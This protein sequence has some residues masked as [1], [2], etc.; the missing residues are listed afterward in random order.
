MWEPVLM[1]KMMQNDMFTALVWYGKVDLARNLSSKDELLAKYGV[2]W[3]MVTADWKC[4][5]GRLEAFDAIMVQVILA[6]TPNSCATSE[7]VH[8]F[9][10]L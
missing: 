2:R 6:L 9:Q 7:D 4:W 1:A 3:V 10:E 8:K 5:I